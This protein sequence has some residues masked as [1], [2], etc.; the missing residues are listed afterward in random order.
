M[1]GQAEMAPLSADDVAQF[2]IDNPEA[3]GAD[4]QQEQA[5]TDESPSDEDTDES[6]TA[7]DSPDDGEEDPAEQP[8]PT[9]SR[10]YKVTVKGEDGADLT[11]EVDEKELVAGYQRHAD[12]SRK[13]AEL[14]RREEQAV[15]IVRAK[16]SEA[17]N[18]YV[19][20]AQMAQALVARLAGLRSPEEMLELSRQDPA[21]YVAEQARQQQVHSMIAGLQN[22]WQQEQFRAQQDQQAALQQSFARC[23]GVLGQ[24]GIDKPKLQHI[25]DSYSKYYGISPERF[26]TL[27]DP[28]VVLSM[29][30]A[31]AYQELQKKK[32]EV[33]Q[34]AAAA[35]RLPQ[36][37]P[38][39]RADTQD[40]KRVERLRSGRG[41][42][43]DLAAF[44]AQHNL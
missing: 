33:T 16:V 39:P 25:F 14:A 19:Q 37:S 12:Y 26:A 20:Q 7:D 8:D 29:R 30:D 27:N 5:P 38:V 17:Q 43:D 24:K 40:K 6:E 23:W 11:Q 1:D 4:D 31:V 42:R 36:K 28:A 34:K 35:P 44:I 22:Q 41:S 32:S 15:E 9:S 3:D 10:K 21:A 13:T 2:L 18:H